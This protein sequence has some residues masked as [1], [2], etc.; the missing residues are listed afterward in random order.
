MGLRYRKSIRLGKGAKINLSKSGIG[1][2]FGVKGARFTKKAGGGTRQTFSIPGTGLSYS[3]DSKKKAKRR[4]PGRAAK[5][6]GSKTVG[7]KTMRVG[8]HTTSTKTVPAGG[9]MIAPNGNA[10]R[11]PK[12]R[13]WLWIL[14]WVFIFPIPLTIILFRN[15]KMKPFIKY[16]VIAAAWMIYLF[17]GAAAQS[18]ETENQGTTPPGQ[19]QEA[20]DDGI[21]R[22]LQE[23]QIE[24]KSAA[25]SL[26]ETQT[27]D[28][29]A[30]SSLQ[31]TQTEDKSAVSSL[32]ETQTEAESAAPSPQEVESIL[33]ESA[34][35]DLV[36]GESVQIRAKVLPDSAEDKNLVWSSSDELIATVDQNGC[37]IGVS[38]GSA[39]ITA[40]AANGV[41]STLDIS[42][43]GSRRR[44]HVSAIASREDKYS[45]GEEWTYYYE[46][47]G[48]KLARE[49]VL[50]VG[51]VLTC[52]ARITEEDKDPD[53]GEA[54]NTHTVTEEDLANGFVVPF[55]LYVTENGGRNSGKSAYYIVHF[56]FTL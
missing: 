6:I 41:V 35:T 21:T 40:T 5:N 44:M 39:V 20:A 25:S 23:T 16:G 19:V 27:E 33:L 45:I 42:V 30:A 43:D 13:T 36:M 51:D 37:V 28:K 11:V 9:N 32:Q 46:V 49:Q 55:D 3:V 53:I 7:T 48:E 10:A 24:D 47:N 22:N 34:G 15:K 8:S 2:S 18:G 14:G 17:I 56:N 54:S 31:E 1:F 29:S 50:A 26:Q 4:P 12:R 52:Y 38:G